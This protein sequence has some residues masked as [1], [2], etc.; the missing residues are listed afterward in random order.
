MK[1]ICCN[2][3]IMGFISLFLF[4][5]VRLEGSESR[6]SI[7]LRDLFNPY[8]DQEHGIIGTVEP[9]GRIEVKIFEEKTNT[10]V[11]H[12]YTS[13]T[14]SN[15]SGVGTSYSRSDLGPVAKYFPKTWNS[16]DLKIALAAIE[17][18]NY[19]QEEFPYPFLSH[20]ID[21]RLEITETNAD[22]KVCKIP[23]VGLVDKYAGNPLFHPNHYCHNLEHANEFVTKAW[24]KFKSPD[25]N[26]PIDLVLAAHR[27]VWGFDKGNGYPENSS[28]AIRATKI[29]TDV[30]ESD[31]MLTGDHKLIAS[32]DYSMY[33]LSNYSGDKGKYIFD[34]SQN[35]YS[36]L[37]LRKKNLEV[38]DY[39]YL[40]FE[41]LIDLIKE[42]NLIF[43]VDIKDLRA[44]YDKDGNC[45]ANEPYDVKAHGDAARQRIFES[46]I[47]I[48]RGCIKIAM[49][50]DAIQYIAFKL[51]H[52]YDSL[53]E[54]IHEDTL[55]QVLYMPVIHPDKQNY[56]DFVDDWC[57]KAEKQLAAW[58]TNYRYMGDRYLLPFERNGKRYDNLLHYV[59]DKTGLRPGQY[60][61]EPMGPQ[62]IVNRW[63]DWKIKDL[64]QDIRGDH[65]LQM[66][67]PYAKIMVLTTDRPDIWLDV[68]DMYN[69][70]YKTE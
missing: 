62:G 54:Y 56:L 28:D 4:Y 24:V 59:Y 39:N 65:Y 52:T 5:S 25:I 6:F 31:V 2:S 68:V 64:R 63:A 11:Y 48:F 8:T 12:V 34:L 29:Y 37:K 33:R 42:N 23:T 67:I 44:R 14:T 60:P 40:M 53:K 32:H 58:Q 17:R 20:I 45:I 43:T 47:E 50:K 22:M 46:W 7:N 21:L 57:M 19:N 27:G 10:L 36:N 26:K 30:L 38:S 13:T 9:G 35:E 69:R 70:M 61:E 51:P 3:L 15:Y 55:S 49:Q 1:G 16:K 66:I 18:Y 41:D